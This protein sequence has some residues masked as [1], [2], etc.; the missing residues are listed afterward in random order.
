MSNRKFATKQWWAIKS[1]LKRNGRW[2]EK[3]AQRRRDAEHTHRPDRRPKPKSRSKPGSSKEP[4]AQ[5]NTLDNY[6]HEG[7][8]E[9]DL[10][11][12]EGFFDDIDLEEGKSLMS[13]Y[14]GS[15]VQHIFSEDSS[16]SS[17][18]SD[19]EI[20]KPNKGDTKDDLEG[21]TLCTEEELS[22]SS[23]SVFHKGGDISR[24]AWEIER[25]FR[26]ISLSSGTRERIRAVGIPEIAGTIRDNTVI[27]FR[28]LPSKFWDEVKEDSD[29]FVDS[30]TV[31]ESYFQTYNS[32]AI[33]IRCLPDDHIST[34]DIFDLL[35]K[36]IDDPFVIICEKSDEGVLHWHM[37][38]FTSKRSDNAKRLLQKALQD[39][40]GSV[41][42]S[43]Q[44]TRSFK[45][46]SKYILKNPITLAVG[47]S[48]ALTKYMFGLM[49]DMGTIK[50]V[51]VGEELGAFPNQMIKDIIHA[52]NLH[53]KYTYEELVFFS[54]EVMKKYLHKPNLESIINN[55]KL[56]LHRPNDARLTFDRITS[57]VCCSDLFPLWF[58]LEYQDLNAND[59]I[60]DFLN[61]MFKISDKVNVLALQGPSNTGKT[62][63]IRPLADIFNWG[64]IVQGGQFMFQNCIN[65]ELMI[66]EEPLIGPDFVE[67]CKRVFE[68][69]TTQVNIK[70]KA[71]QTLYRTPI[72]ITTNK[73]VWH[74]C[75][76]DKAAFENRMF[77]YKFPYS[78]KM[79]SFSAISIRR[80]YKRYRQWLTDLSIYF[81][82]CEPYCSSGPQYSAAENTSSICWQHRKLYFDNCNSDELDNTGTTGG[83][84]CTSGVNDSG[85]ASSSGRKSLK[86]TERSRPSVDDCTTADDCLS[87]AGTP[88]R[89]SPGRRSEPEEGLTLY[90]T[91][92]RRSNKELGGGAKRCTAESYGDRW[93]STDLV[94]LRTC[95]LQLSAFGRRYKCLEKIFREN[96]LSDQPRVDWELPGA[97]LD[98]LLFEPVD[99]NAWLTLLKIGFLC[100]KID[101]R[102]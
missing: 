88:A 32:I 26:D 19:R 37:I 71:P 39:V 8:V 66:W 48:D 25:A 85:R 76:A 10:E 13:N 61:V 60:M 23:V 56:F 101:N 36:T 14:G 83:F 70:F 29:Y 16:A 91:N 4:Q 46:L 47:N 6:V 100:A 87:R 20:C 96:Q 2:D 67:M 64:E 78:G 74:Y 68:G 53:K 62:T 22:N 51:E 98:D 11:I 86:R 72:L 21:Q 18:G 34:K 58:F 50:P 52:M 57:D 90:T 84:E 54:P 40:P 12:P 99:K 59:F 35:I 65:K 7:T 1:S 55:C 92:V 93:D 95:I 28:S 75:E 77:L 82:G 30:F 80:S 94:N 3:R 49:K 81:T 44:Q 42:I 97:K 41:S 17:N 102:I 9:D 63:F 31:Y 5:D 79:S 69:M 43:C 24:E 33:V 38:W 27:L 15:Q 73:D 89:D 45:H